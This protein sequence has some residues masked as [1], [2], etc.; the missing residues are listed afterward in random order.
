M[1]RLVAVVGPTAVGKTRLAVDLALK[2]HGEIVNADSRQ[3]YR[4]MDIG[5]AKPGDSDRASVPHHLI[6]I[7]DP[8]ESFSLALYRQK[9]LEAIA[10]IFSRGKTPLLVGGTGQYIWAIL[11]G[12]TIPPV[13]PDLAFRTKL[14]QEAAT[15]GHLG[16]HERLESV[17]PE[18]A[19]SIDPAN[20]RRV[21]RALEVWHSTGIPFSCLRQKKRPPFEFLILGLTLPR[22]ALYMHI[23]DRVD[24]MIANGL[25]DEVRGLQTMG[26]DVDLPPMTGI[27]Y[28]EI[29]SYLVNEN[30]LES[31]VKKIK[32]RTHHLARRQYTWFRLNDARI[33]WLPADQDCLKEGAEKVQTFLGDDN[34]LY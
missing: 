33:S 2:F 24:W 31:T 29:S 21:I 25:V 7:L 17:D 34:G 19:Q 9:A 3:V 28:M 16:L 12:W 8:R 4:Y 11:E 32:Y 15:T 20:V 10:D 1:Q 14:E 30:D 27:G 6:D 13:A 5:T 26:Y 22:A 18:A 23:D